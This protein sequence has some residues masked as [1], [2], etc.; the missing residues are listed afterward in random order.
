MHESEC[1]GQCNNRV[2]NDEPKA[3]DPDFLRCMMSLLFYFVTTLIITRQL[4]NKHDLLVLID[5]SQ[6]S[7]IACAVSAFTFP[8]TSSS[9]FAERLERLI[10]WF[11]QM[12]LRWSDNLVQKETDLN[13]STASELCPSFNSFVSLVMEPNRHTQENLLDDLALHLAH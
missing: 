4:S 9:A 12:Y 7:P 2:F 10:R 3:I 1:R 11:G 6:L 8:V 5:P 13:R